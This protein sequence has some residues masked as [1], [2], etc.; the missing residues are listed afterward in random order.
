[1]AENNMKTLSGFSEEL[2]RLSASASERV[3][4]LDSRGGFP[5]SGTIWEEGRGLTRREREVLLMIAEGLSNKAI[6][7]ELG[8][9]THTVKFHVASTMQK[10]GAASRTEA[11]TLGLRLG[12]IFL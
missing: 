1:M 5:T 2:E 6:A 9:S 7:Y 8:I 12:L 3:V 10:L 11:V 4:F